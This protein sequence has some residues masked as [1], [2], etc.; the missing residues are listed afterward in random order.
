[1][2]WQLLAVSGTAVAII[3]VFTALLSIWKV[4]AEPAIV[5]AG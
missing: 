1:M 3:T 2:P 5:F 4:V